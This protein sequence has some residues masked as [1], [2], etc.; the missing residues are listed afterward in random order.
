MRAKFST[1][2]EDSFLNH[3]CDNVSVNSRDQDQS[4]IEKCDYVVGGIGNSDWPLYEAWLGAAAVFFCDA[5]AAAFLGG[6]MIDLVE[7]NGK[8]IGFRM[9]YWTPESKIIVVG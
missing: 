4:T 1:Y 6:M 2:C 5:A 7:V 8:R 9:R 3:I